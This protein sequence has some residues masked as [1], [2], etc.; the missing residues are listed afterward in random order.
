MLSE[1]IICIEFRLF[2][3]TIHIV[4][5]FWLTKFRLHLSEWN[6]SVSL[7]IKV[8]PSLNVHFERA[9]LRVLYWGVR[10]IA[11]DLNDSCCHLEPI[12]NVKWFINSKVVFLILTSQLVVFLIQKVVKLVGS[13]AEH[14]YESDNSEKRANEGA[15][16]VGVRRHQKSKRSSITVK[17]QCA[18][19]NSLAGRLLF[20]GCSF[21]HQV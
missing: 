17:L 5:I 6:S 18:R 21:D 12:F 20:T 10:W 16:P 7:F 1:F 11:V 9:N 8:V 15:V 4:E 2:I 14:D 19:L 3:C 13:V